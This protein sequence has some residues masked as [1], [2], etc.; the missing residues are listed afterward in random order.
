[1]EE[2]L[3][4]FKEWEKS[5]KWP[6]FPE[7]IMCSDGSGELKV[8]CEDLLFNFDRIDQLIQYF[9]DNTIK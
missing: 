6:Y 7:I 1:M 3:K 8:G 2:F 5:N 9:K 4:I